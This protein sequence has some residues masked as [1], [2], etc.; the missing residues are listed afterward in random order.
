MSRVLKL[1]F[2]GIDEWNRPVFKDEDSK[3]PYFYGDTQHL[4]AL[5]AQ[6]WE[7][8]R[9]YKDKDLHEHLVF[10]GNYYGCEPSGEH[11][12]EWIDICIEGLDVVPQKLHLYKVAWCV[13]GEGGVKNLI[14][15][16]PDSARAK[17]LNIKYSLTEGGWVSLLLLE[18]DEN[19]EMK[20]KKN[21]QS[22]N[23]KT[24]S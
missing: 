24:D 6:E 4:F 1:K 3:S 12:E 13:P 7:V 16:N 2:V 9:Y 8:L 23:E 22:Y 10:F 19:H 17:Y 21:L 18:E 14:L 15:T 20:V 11:V 5:D